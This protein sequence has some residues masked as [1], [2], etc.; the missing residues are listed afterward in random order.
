MK[1]NE[2][3]MVWQK[4]IDLV[5]S[6]YRLTESFPNSERY[7]LTSQVQ[8]ASVSAPANI[9]EGSGRDSTKDYLRFLSIA[10]GSLAEVTTYFTILERRGYCDTNQLKEAVG[11]ANEVGRL[12]SGLQRSLRRRLDQEIL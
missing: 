1:S 3:L 4:A 2:D 7:G 10:K 12:L 8:R 5:D 9:A 6:V 11:L